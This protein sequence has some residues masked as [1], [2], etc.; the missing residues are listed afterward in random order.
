MIPLTFRL[1]L[2]SLQKLEL[3]PP[4][5]RVLSNS[6]CVENR[7]AAMFSSNVLLATTLLLLGCSGAPVDQQPLDREQVADYPY[8]KDP[9]DRK[10]D[11]YGDDK[12]PLP[13]VRLR[14]N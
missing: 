3:I 8:S 12:Q 13:V 11:T 1:P 2:G 7:A 9:Y 14:S 4:A 10:H 5:C 6:F